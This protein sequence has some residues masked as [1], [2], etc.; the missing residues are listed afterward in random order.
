MKE[1]L[2]LNNKVFN[3]I[4]SAFKKYIFKDQYHR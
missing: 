1:I 3:T 2:V 4:P